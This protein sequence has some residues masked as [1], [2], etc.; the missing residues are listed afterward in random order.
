MIDFKTEITK[1]KQVLEVGEVE[2][3]INSDEIQ[4]MMELLD[5]LSK[6]VKTSDKE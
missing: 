1:Y 2:N 5:K 3:A 4:D 6:Q